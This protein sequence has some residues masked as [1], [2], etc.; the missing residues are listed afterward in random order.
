LEISLDTRRNQI[1]LGSN[2]LYQ[3][4]FSAFFAENTGNAC[5]GNVYVA[6]QITISPNSFRIIKVK[7]QSSNQS[8]VAHGD[9]LM[10]TP[11]PAWQICISGSI[12]EVSHSSFPLVFFN[13]TQDK[14]T[15]LRGK[16][17]GHFEL[18]PDDLASSSGLIA[19]CA[20]NEFSQSNKTQVDLK[21]EWPNDEF[22]KHVNTGELTDKSSEKFKTFICKFKD[23]FART[24][25]DIG[26]NDLDG[27]VVPIDETVPIKSK[28][29]FPLP[30]LMQEV[31]MKHV[32]EML[33]AKIIEVGRSPFNSP[34][35]I[36]GKPNKE[37]KILPKHL[38]NEENSRFLIDLR[39]VNKGIKDSQ[40][41]I[42]R[43]EEVITD[44]AGKKQFSTLDIKHS[45][46]ACNLSEESRQLFSFN[47]KGMSYRFL[48]AP[49]GAKSSPRQ[50]LE[51]LGI[52]FRDVPSKTNDEINF[53]DFLSWYVDDLTIHTESEKFEDHLRHLQIV[54]ERIREF[55][56]KLNL[57]KCCF[58]ANSVNLLGFKVS[59]EGI[60]PQESKVEAI[61]AMTPPK[62]VSDVRS[63]LGMTSFLRSFYLNYAEISY[64][65]VRLTR[66][67]VPFVFG[68]TE[69]EA[70]EKLKSELTNPHTILL[71]FPSKSEDF[72]L[73]TDASMKAISALLCVKCKTTDRFQI[74]ASYSKILSGPASRYDN[75][76]RELFALFRD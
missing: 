11:S 22:L 56:L 24:A 42:R 70:F 19:A 71:R 2:S 69:M 34:V 3:E 45:F 32:K 46:Y 40:W 35:F 47:V 18:L 58:F 48:K 39:E 17:M 12:S 52:I 64:P 28:K 25:Y 15:L 29:Q 8:P 36:I 9:C 13:P 10:F 59:P 30:F 53:S 49:M 6:K 67:N 41:E 43:I 38:W 21:T 20:E 57:S 44:M 27:F 16:L 23:V 68:P 73:F 50:F 61:R 33:R 63:F 51:F 75:H 54:F 62:D 60:S 74:V 1:S 14:V 31:I 4:N 72:H 65:L 55:N 7:P 5:T 26:G 76:N 66:K 37:G